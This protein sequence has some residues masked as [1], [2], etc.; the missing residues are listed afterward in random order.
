MKRWL[1][2]VCGASALVCGVSAGLGADWPQYRCDVSRS[3]SATQG[4]AQELWLR[5]VRQLPTPRPAFRGEVRLS[6]D[7]SYEPVVLGQTMFVPSM[8]ND[9][10]AALDVATG[11][12]RWRFF[13]EGPVRFAPVAWEGSVYFVSDDG[14]LYCVAA[15]DG[16]L[17]WKFR[18]AADEKTD[19]KLLGSGRLIS[20]FPAR[21]GPVL[22]DGVIY[23]G[24][25]IWSGYGVAIHALDARSG[26][27]VWSNTESN[28][29][30]KANMDHGI[31]HDAGLTPQG[32]LAIVHETLVVPCGAQLPAFLDLKTGALN[33]YSMGWGGRNGLPKGTWFVAGA[34]RKSPLRNS[35][36][37]RRRVAK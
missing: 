28:R 2:L 9:S 13:A 29:I 30:A 15:A 16:K 10:V 7:A 17:R 33:T 1:L 31:A 3:A 36:P 18:G 6:F 21:G 23:F 4:L 8:V 34:R 35:S 5:W 37:L 26:K 11:A 27:V 25:G 20:L 14:Y 22:K 19:R 24:A 12:E 32:Y